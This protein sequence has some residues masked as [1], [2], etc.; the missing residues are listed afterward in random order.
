[1]EGRLTQLMRLVGCVHTTSSRRMTVGLPWGIL[2]NQIHVIPQLSAMVHFSYN[3]GALVYRIQLGLGD[4]EH[5]E[6]NAQCLLHG[7]LIA[8][9]HNVLRLFD[10]PITIRHRQRASN[11]TEIIEGYPCKE[12]KVSQT[13]RV[14]R[15]W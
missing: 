12:E 13:V 9:C 1:M 8:D 7:V 14:L 3:F 2:L 10:V 11:P 6:K 5:L 15:H 4:I